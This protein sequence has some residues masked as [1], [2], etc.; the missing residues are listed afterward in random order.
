MIDQQELKAQI[1]H[2]KRIL[3]FYSLYGD[4]VVKQGFPQKELEKLI[5]IQ[6]E[7]LNNLLRQLKD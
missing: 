2:V 7:K 5:D 6:L 3:K 1:E 4:D